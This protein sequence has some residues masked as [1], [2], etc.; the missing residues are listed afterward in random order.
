MA[1]VDDLIEPSQKQIR[2]LG[3]IC[4]RRLGIASSLRSSRRDFGPLMW[5][6]TARLRSSYRV[7]PVIAAHSPITGGCNSPNWKPGKGFTVNP[8]ARIA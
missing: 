7:P 2:R 8:Q 3:G 6:T 4:T 1:H 5:P